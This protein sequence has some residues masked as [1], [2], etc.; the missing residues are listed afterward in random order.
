[1]EPTPSP[2][3]GNNRVFVIGASGNVGAIVARLL[4]ERDYA[5]V[6][7]G[8]NEPRHAVDWHFFDLSRLDRSLPTLHGESLICTANI[9]S[10]TPWIEKFAA[11]GVR[12]LI[13]FSSTSRFTKQ[14]SGSAYELKVA[15]DLEQS[16]LEVAAECDRLG[17]AWTI[18]RPTLI[19]GGH[20]GD[21][22]IA[23]IA[24]LIKR[25]RFFPLLSDG[26]GKR[27]PV[28]AYALAA[29]CIQA[30]PEK[31]TF[32]RSYNLS[33]GETLTYR[34]MVT[35]VFEALEIRPTFV[36]VP[37][38]LFR[39][40]VAGARLMPRFRHLTVDMAKRMQQDMVFDH[41]DAAKD[42][43]YDPGAFDPSYLRKIFCR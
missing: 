11:R 20:R 22:N 23:D 31:Q 28:S 10:L 30:F 13:A 33:G 38:S 2:D 42:F 35:R 15:S 25:L 27:Q 43:R 17:I 34:E 24:R 12:R 9:W 7:L 5:V 36:R 6:S 41:S 29:A 37:V 40:A 39:F 16:E 21:R 26:S 14:T 4:R 1:M 8:R 18:L 19:Y 32:S 3:T